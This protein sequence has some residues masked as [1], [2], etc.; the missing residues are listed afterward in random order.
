MLYR[1][2]EE[3]RDGNDLTTGLSF[4]YAHDKNDCV[5]RL[6]WKAWHDVR[7]NCD[8]VKYYVNRHETDTDFHLERLYINDFVVEADQEVFKVYCDHKSYTPE[9]KYER[10]PRKK[11]IKWC[12]L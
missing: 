7:V 3:K 6:R 5:R 8:R 11:T 2:Y 4:E 1:I 12:T 9:A 10:V